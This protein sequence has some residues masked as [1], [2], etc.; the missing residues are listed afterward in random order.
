MPSCRFR[1]RMG[2]SKI[3]TFRDWIYAATFANWATAC[4]VVARRGVPAATIRVSGG[5][6]RPGCRIHASRGKRSLQRRLPGAG[7]RR[8]SI[9]RYR[10]PEAWILDDRAKFVRDVSCTI[11]MLLLPPLKIP[12]PDA[13]EDQQTECQLAERDATAFDIAGRGGASTTPDS[14]SGSSKDSAAV[15]LM[16]SATECSRGESDPPP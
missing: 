16:F 9:S 1:I 6:S 3:R 7:T 4:S 10:S 15:L 2:R 11:V 14:K 8:T 5:M 12:V 13:G